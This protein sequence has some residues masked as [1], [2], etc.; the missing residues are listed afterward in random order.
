MGPTVGP[1]GLAATLV[2]ARLVPGRALAALVGQTVTAVG[3]EV[4]VDV[5]LWVLL[6]LA[7]VVLLRLLG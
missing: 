4:R 3:A 1:S 6:V 5:L 2:A 7:H